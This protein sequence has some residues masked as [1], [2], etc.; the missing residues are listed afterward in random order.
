MF[1]G[2]I[3]SLVSLP[4]AMSFSISI[5]LG[6]ELGLYSAIFGGFIAAVFGGSETNIIGPTGAFVA[7]LASIMIQY[8]YEDLLIAGMLS[9]IILIMA[10]LF[11]LGHFIQYVPYPV[12]LGF[13]GGIGIIIL[14]TQL[15]TM[16]G[17]EDLVKYEYFHENIIEFLRNVGSLKLSALLLTLVTILIIQGTMWFSS[18]LPAPLVGIILSSLAVYL[19]DIEVKTIQDV[20][21]SIPQNLPAIKIPYVSFGKIITLLPMA[22]TIASLAAIETLLSALTSDSMK[23]ANHNSKFELVGVGLANFFTPFFGGIPVSGAIARTTLNAKS[24]SKSRIAAMMNALFLLGMM[25]LLAPLVNHI[26]LAALAGILVLLSIKMVDVEVA[27][28]LLRD[29]DW[30]DFLLLMVTFLLTIFVGLTFGIAVGMAIA[31]M[32]FLKNLSD[33]TVSRTVVKKLNGELKLVPTDKQIKCDHLGIYTIDVPLFFGT[34]RSIVRSLSTVA[35]T[36]ATILRLTHLSGIDATGINALKEI[37]DMHSVRHKIYLS[38]IDAKSK[39]LFVKTGLLKL[40]G[41]DHIFENTQEAINAALAAQGLSEGCNA[42]KIL[43]G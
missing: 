40:I 30:T 6:P 24:G 31:S 28:Q 8:G 16:F 35:H 13:T 22:F 33:E 27:Y 17:L 21:G 18:K 32:V 4:L 36:E 9:G 43:N 15:G 23:G 14:S 5:G 12:I 25:L 41:A 2:L 39:K 29:H 1:S 19:F 34:A 42:Y 7:V 38:G 10:G 11:R 20:F 3:V 26:P 37:L